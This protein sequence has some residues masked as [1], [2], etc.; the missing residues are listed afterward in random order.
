MFDNFNEKNVQLSSFSNKGLGQISKPQKYKTPEEKY[1]IK[2]AIIFS[3]FQVETRYWETGRGLGGCNS[4]NQHHFFSSTSLGKLCF[5]YCNSSTQPFLHS[6]AIDL[7][8]FVATQMLLFI[9][10]VRRMP[11]LSR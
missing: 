6:V 1:P 4:I 9:L 8:L 3:F 11:V 7:D 5:L 10:F 2:N